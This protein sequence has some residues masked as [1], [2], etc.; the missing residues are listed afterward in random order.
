MRQ[1]LRSPI[2]RA[3][4]NLWTASDPLRLL[5]TYTTIEQTTST[6][7]VSRKNDALNVSARYTLHL[8]VPRQMTKCWVRFLSD[9]GYEPSLRAHHYSGIGGIVFQIFAE[10]QY[11]KIL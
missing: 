10:R 2:T 4:V 5:Y 8:I 3:V 1:T 9:P 6:K 11:R 7:L